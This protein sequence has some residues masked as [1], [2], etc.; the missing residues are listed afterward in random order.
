MSQENL[1]TLI[2]ESFAGV[3]EVYYGIV[4]VVNT[5]ELAQFVPIPRAP[6]YF[7]VLLFQH[8]A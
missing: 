1:P 7:F 6:K 3:K 5:R 4:H 8:N 2:M